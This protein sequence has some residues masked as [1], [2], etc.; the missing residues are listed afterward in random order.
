MARGDGDL[1]S[2]RD[3]K[4]VAMQDYP[5]RDEAVAAVS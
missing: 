3:A 4:I 2:F 5:T 1:I